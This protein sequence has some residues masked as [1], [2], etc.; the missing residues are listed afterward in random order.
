MI[1]DLEQCPTQLIL[2]RCQFFCPNPD[3]FGILIIGG[4]DYFIFQSSVGSPGSIILSSKDESMTTDAY[5]CPQQPAASG[6][7]K[8]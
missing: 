4:A 7:D 3:D 8:F 6:K 5:Q 1:F 2:N